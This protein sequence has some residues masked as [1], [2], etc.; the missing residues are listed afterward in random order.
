MSAPEGQ[1][2][3]K[4]ATVEMSVLTLLVVLFMIVSIGCQF[5]AH[6]KTGFHLAWGADPA[7]SVGIILAAGLT[8]VMYS[9]LYR[10]N[11]LF[12]V[13]ENLYVGVALGYTAILVWRESLRTDVYEPLFTSPTWSAFAHE[14]LTRAVPIVLGLFLLTQLS[15]RHSW[16]SRYTYALLIGWGAGVAIPVTMHSFILKQLY[17]AIAPLQNSINPSGPVATH[18]GAWF[19]NIGL[20][21]LGAV[22][23]LV[24]TVTVLFYFFFSIE[25][26]R[27]GAA[28]SKV[29]ILFLMVAFGASFGYT[30]MARMSLLIGRVQFLLFDWLRI[31]PPS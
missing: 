15:R 8:L 20:P 25:H 9:F 28:V 29:G 13:A 31:S 30:V 24:G 1:S 12:K 7:K 2:G 10:D 5:I 27:G 26:K 3:K 21:I 14:A 22:I 23:L 4:M 6:D 16:L 11:A 19:V 17:A 18:A